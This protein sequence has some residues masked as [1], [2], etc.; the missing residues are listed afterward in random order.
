MKKE[1]KTV[2][3]SQ[4]EYDSLVACAELVKHPEVIKRTYDAIKSDRTV[5]FEEAFSQ[6]SAPAANSAAD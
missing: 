5:S 2:T 1:D 4:Q 6:T 3:I